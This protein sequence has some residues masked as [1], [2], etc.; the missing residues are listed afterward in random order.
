MVQA[1]ERQLKPVGDA[2]LVVDLAQIILDH[3]LCRAELVGN[4]F[5]ALALRD[6]GDDRHFFRRKPRLALRAGQRG[7]LRAIGLD[8]PVHRLV[9]DPGL[10]LRDLAD[11]FDQQIRRDR[12]GNDAANAAT[13]ELDRVLLVGVI[14][15]G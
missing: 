10:S 8:D 3:L 11:A 2:E 12:P 15:P 14:R 7:C 4:F 1:I 5:I 6:A 13:V 9:I